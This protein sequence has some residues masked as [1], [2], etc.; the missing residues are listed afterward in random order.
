MSGPVRSATTPSNPTDASDP[1]TSL[2]PI[3]RGFNPDPTICVVLASGGTPTIFFLSTSTFEYFPGCA[4]YTSTD[5]LNRE[6]I[7]HALKRRSQ[8]ELRTVKPGADSWASTLRYR[9]D[10]GRWYLANCLFQRYR[11]ASDQRIFPRGFYVFTD[12]IWDDNAWSDPVYFGDPGFDQDLFWDDDGKVYLSTTTRLSDRAP[13]STQ[14]DLA[15]HISQMNICT[16]RTLTPPV[17]IRRSPHGIAEGSHIIGRN[18]IYHLF[19]AGGGTEAGH[20]GPDAPAMLLR[21]QT[22]FFQSLEVTMEF[23]TQQ[24]GA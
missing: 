1:P 17:V 23:S 13:D 3:L 6:L 15:I 22:S 18:R 2:N 4:I 5:L 10:E 8:I 16:G 7:G 20:Q 14:K 11:P 21:R 19:T 12:N 24:R 9:P